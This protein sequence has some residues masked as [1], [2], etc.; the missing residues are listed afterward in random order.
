MGIEDPSIYN[1]TYDEIDI[2]STVLSE[3]NW[4]D[5]ISQ[6]KESRNNLA[7]ILKISMDN[8]INISK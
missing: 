3:T 2:L 1:V 5:S 6:I 7:A 8:L 4:T